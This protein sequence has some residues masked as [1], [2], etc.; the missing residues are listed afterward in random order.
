MILYHFGEMLCSYINDISTTSSKIFKSCTEH[1]EYTV[2][3]TIRDPHRKSISCILNMIQILTS[4]PS[5]MCGSLQ[6]HFLKVRQDIKSS[7]RHYPNETICVLTMLW[8]LQTTIYHNYYSEHSWGYSTVSTVS[9]SLRSWHPVIT[10]CYNVG[11]ANIYVKDGS[12]N[13]N[14]V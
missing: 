9:S 5:P 10:S 8:P 7:I 3:K 2:Q 13:C 1:Q 6:N 11:H 14:L 4:F 12:A